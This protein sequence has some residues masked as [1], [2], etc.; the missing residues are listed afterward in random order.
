MQLIEHDALDLSFLTVSVKL[1]LMARVALRNAKETWMY[2]YLI[3]LYNS[4]FFIILQK[5][6]LRLYPLLYG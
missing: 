2:F 3:S 5:C 4:I 6:L 1:R